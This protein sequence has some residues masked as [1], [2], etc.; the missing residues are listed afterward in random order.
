MTP[1]NPRVHQGGSV[2]LIVNATRQLGSEPLGYKEE[3]VLTI[4]DLP[5]GFSVSPAAIAPNQ[6]QATLTITAPP[7][8]P[9]GF[10]PITVIGTGAVREQRVTR[11]AQPLGTVKQ[12][13]QN[14][15]RPTSG[16]FLTIMES[17][18][19]LV[20]TIPVSLSLTQGKSTSC[21]VSATRKSGYT[22]AISLLV[23]GL[24]RG[25][26][27]SQANIAENQNQATLT[28]TAAGDASVGIQ[29]LVV[30][31]SVTINNQQVSTA[32]VAIPLVVFE[33]PFVLT[34]NPTDP[35]IIQ[36]GA[37]VIPQEGAVV[38]TVNVTRKGF[39]TGAIALSVEGL[40]EGVT[41][42]EASIAE[43][44]SEG[45]ILLTADQNAKPGSYKNVI[46]KGAA[47]VNNQT[48]TQPA[49]AVTL[50]VTAK[51]ETASAPPSQQ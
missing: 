40:P 3:I 49:A 9:V 42:A 22:G 24:P 39:F 7:D 27:A 35:T 43:G 44:Q 51:S 2:A 16:V 41:A 45:T 23:S 11:Q 38:A 20:T 37:V 34:A 33:A 10:M 29:N 21:G 25:V 36:G 8:A 15:T 31:G 48:I 47:T 28:L 50:I 13:N 1:D 30:S 46:V 14:L 6:T 12:G 4:P 5:K 17:P 18:E 32:A 19:F 26:S